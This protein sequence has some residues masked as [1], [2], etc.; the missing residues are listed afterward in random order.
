MLDQLQKHHIGIVVDT[1]QVDSL[2]QQLNVAFHWDKIQGVNV[3]FHWNPFLNLYEEYFTLEGRAKNYKLGFHH[4]CYTVESSIQMKKIEEYLK[5]FNLGYRLTFPEKSGS[6]E[7][8]VVTF[9]YIHY[10]GIVEFNIKSSI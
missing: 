6:P 1:F 2:K 4:V 5:K 9:Y 10:V 3:A 8:E 7:C